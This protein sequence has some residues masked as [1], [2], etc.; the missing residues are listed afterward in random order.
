MLRVMLQKDRN[1][2]ITET[3]LE[4]DEI[5]DDMVLFEPKRF[6]G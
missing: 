4:E 6:E 5:I 1:E 2:V 3:R